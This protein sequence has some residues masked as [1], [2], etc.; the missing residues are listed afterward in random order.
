[1]AKTE[2]CMYGST[3]LFSV[4]ITQSKYLEGKDLTKIL[5]VLFCQYSVGIIRLIDS[6]AFAFTLEQQ[7]NGY[8]EI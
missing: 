2:V 3:H 4:R 6:A 7:R 5:Q 8:V 1:M